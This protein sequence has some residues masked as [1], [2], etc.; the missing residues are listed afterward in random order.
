MEYLQLYSEK[1]YKMDR[2]RYETII[3]KKTSHTKHLMNQYYHRQR[4]RRI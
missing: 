3:K 4:I 1:K 2:N